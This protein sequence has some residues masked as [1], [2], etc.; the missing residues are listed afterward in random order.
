MF[1]GQGG[2]K[3]ED[4]CVW[5]MVV[6]GAA[7]CGGQRAA[8]VKVKVAPPTQLEMPPIDARGQLIS[9]K[10]HTVEVN[11]GSCAKNHRSQFIKCSYILKV[12]KL[13]VIY[14]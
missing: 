12:N 7:G 4:G 14:F 1:N 10:L 6:S 2:E 5:Q 9:T 11:R 3:D 8:A 13:A